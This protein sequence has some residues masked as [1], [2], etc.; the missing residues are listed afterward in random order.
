MSGDD[1]RMDKKIKIIIADDNRN[2]CQMLT[3]YLQTQDDLI[4]VGVALPG[5]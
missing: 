2:L 4:V 5:F 1:G 3:N